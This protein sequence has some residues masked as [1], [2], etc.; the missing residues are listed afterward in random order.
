MPTNNELCRMEATELAGRVRA[1][2]VSPVEVVD[3]VLERMERLEPELHA[4]C[5]PTPE[6]AREA[7][8]PWKDRWPKL[9]DDLGL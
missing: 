2:E 6:L 4:F 8:R 3:A 1:K 9:L 5:T 7:A